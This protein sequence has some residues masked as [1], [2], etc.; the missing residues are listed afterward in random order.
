M[1]LQPPEDYSRAQWPDI[2]RKG[3]NDKIS[4]LSGL[5]LDEFGLIKIP[6]P[7]A[8]R[9]EWSA[10]YEHV[11]LAA[12]GKRSNVGGLAME[13]WAQTN[14]YIYLRGASLAEYSD[15]AW[16]SASLSSAID[17]LEIAQTAAYTLY[18]RTPSVQPVLYTPYYPKEMPRTRLNDEFYYNSEQLVEYSVTYD[19][20]PGI[21]QQPNA[22]LALAYNVYCQLPE[23]TAEALYAIAETAGLTALDAEALPEAVAQFVQNCA[24][25][26]LNPSEFPEGADFAVWFL[27]E[28]ERGYCVHFATATATMLRALGI[29]ARYVTGFV[30]DARMNRWVEVTDHD[31]HAWVEYWDNSIGWVPL[32][33]TPGDGRVAGAVVELPEEEPAVEIDPIDPQPNEVPKPDTPDL[34]ALPETED[35]SEVIESAQEQTKFQL[36][37][38]LLGLFAALFCSRWLRLLWRRLQVRGD[39]NQRALALWKQI[40]RLASHLN[41]NP[42]PEAQ[43]LAEK[44]RFSRHQLSPDEL[45]VLHGS[46]KALTECLQQQEGFF[47]WLKVRWWWAAC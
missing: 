43:A 40:A 27:T 36:R 9:V 22:Y 29:P 7:V 38:V 33:S 5:E 20:T 23:D 19:P 18:I 21:T 10:S 14:G 34:P 8:P 25:Y 28:A 2:I 16:H 35:H 42:P 15:N 41:I 47:T 39:A 11:D 17:P 46:I 13:L 4:Q 45:S 30:T 6:K 26:D 32:E 24:Q 1:L 12:L 37:W 31:A 44:A 3:I